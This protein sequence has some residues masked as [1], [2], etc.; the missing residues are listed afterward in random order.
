MAVDPND[1]NV[2]YIGGRG[3]LRVDLT[4]VS[5]VYSFVN[6]DFSDPTANSAGTYTQDTTVGDAQSP[7]AKNPPGG[8]FNDFNGLLETDSTG[9]NLN[10]LSMLRDAE[11]PFLAPTSLSFTGTSNIRN[12]GSDIKWQFFEY[13]TNAGTSGLENQILTVKDPLTGLVRLIN[14]TASGVYTTVVS[15]VGNVANNVTSVGSV[16]SVS[17]DRNGNLQIGEITSTGVQPSTL[18]GAVSGALLYAENVRIGVPMSDPN[19]FQ[20]GNIAWGNL[21]LGWGEMVAPDPTGSGLV[22]K[23][24]YPWT[25]SG[26]NGS[27]YLWIRFWIR[28]SMATISS[29]SIRS[30]RFRPPAL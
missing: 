28:R 7:V 22:F 5:D 23:Y 15:N 29:R 13:D 2:L 19:L 6:F 9:N 12:D 11:N 24:Q 10:V 26:A 20:D 16:T 8:V 27:Q 21:S 14:A 1:P 25:D 17:G 3:L 18:A 30:A 4:A